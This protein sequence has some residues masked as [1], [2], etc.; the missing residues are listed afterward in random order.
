[1]RLIGN[2]IPAVLPMLAAIYMSASPAV[3]ADMRNMP[4]SVAR[5][6]TQAAFL[7]ATRQGE[8][9]GIPNLRLNLGSYDEEMAPFTL[10]VKAIL[11]TEYG[12]PALPDWQGG[13]GAEFVQGVTRVFQNI[14]QLQVA[15]VSDKPPEFSREISERGVEDVRRDLAQL[16]RPGGW[17]DGTSMGKPKVHPYKAA[18]AKLAQ[19][20]GDAMAAWA[21]AERKRRQV[22]YAEEQ[23]QAQ[24]EADARAAKQRA[25]EQQRIDAD[26]ARIE[27]DEKRRQQAKKSKVAG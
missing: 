4:M 12:V 16:Q 21:D 9:T 3:A 20:F 27:A 14:A 13:C 23:K 8:F 5:W 18:A 26:R 1:M 22:A 2:K 11:H 7:E 15:T 6:P 17:C 10:S 24:A 25:A 19:A